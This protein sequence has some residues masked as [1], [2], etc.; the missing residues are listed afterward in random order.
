MRVLW[1][2]TSPSRG[3]GTRAGPSSTAA[4]RAW[5]ELSRTFHFL[6]RRAVFELKAG[7]AER[8]EALIAEAQ[9]RLAEP[10]PLWLALL[11]EAI[12]YKLPK[13]D[14]DRF[15]AQWVKALT[16]E[17]PERD[18]RG[19]GGADGRLP[20]RRRRLPRPGRARQA[21]DRTTSAARPGSSIAART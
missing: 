17:G 5:P 7:Q 3:A 10:T 16:E 4:E 12:R 11:I 8:A 9:E 15:E 2:G 6:A 19:A 18:G 21:G 20:G 13:A 14:Q 1:R